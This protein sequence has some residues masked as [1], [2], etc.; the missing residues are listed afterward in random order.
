[1][2]K[3][4][5]ESRAILLAARAE[6]AKSFWSRLW[7]LMGRASLPHDTALVI[8]PNSSVHTFWMR[9]PIDVI[10]VDRNDIVVG[11][12]EAMPPNR[13]YA[14]A[15]KAYRTIELPAGV[16]QRTGTQRGDRLRFEAL[17]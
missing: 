13:P 7:G 5:N 9:F 11:L 6:V 17:G 15:W 8:V 4:S 16:I 1:M 10:F 2:M 14:G 12:R 3:I